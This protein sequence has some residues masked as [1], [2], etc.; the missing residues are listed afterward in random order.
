MIYGRI[1]SIKNKKMYDD[2]NNLILL[3]KEDLL[4]NIT[5]FEFQKNYDNECFPNIKIVEYEYI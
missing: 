4:L 1:F 3:K 5:P 2:L